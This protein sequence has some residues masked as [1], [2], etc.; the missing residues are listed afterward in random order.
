MELQVD[1]ALCEAAVFAVFRAAERGQGHPLA[2]A[3]GRERERAYEAT[4]DVETRPPVFAKLHADWFVRLELD[5]PLQG[6]MDAYPGLRGRLDR[7]LVMGAPRA[8]NEGAELYVHR[9]GKST[10]V[11]RIM[12][13]RF[14]DL[15]ML[16]GWLRVELASVFDMLDPAFGYRPEL[17]IQG[18]D[19]AR[20][21]LVRD[22]YR[23]LWE[24]S[25]DARF[26]PHGW[27]SGSVPAQRGV[28][29]LSKVFR[30]LEGEK[31]TRIRSH[32]GSPEFARH[33]EL[34]RLALDPTALDQPRP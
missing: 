30:G 34:V 15:A 14:V 1:P 12:A 4:P 19:P 25:I 16:A 24:L 32:V 2:A 8:K 29:L 5:R 9:S 17:P 31:L 18:L 28:A 23:V 11:I 7:T 3:Y 10:T 27:P 6:A 26:A 21:D 33:D 13:E 22:R 20:A